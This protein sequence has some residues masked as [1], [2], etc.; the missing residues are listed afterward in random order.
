MSR[1]DGKVVLVMGG[2]TDGPPNAGEVLA[3]GNGRAI[4]IQCARE[5]ARVMVADRNGVAAQETVDVIRE[6]GHAA[7][8]TAC[9]LLD[10]GQ[11]Q[12]AVEQTVSA[13]GQLDLLANNAGITDYS[14]VTESLQDEFDRIL[15]VNLRG[16]VLAIKYALP[17]IAKVGGGAIVNISSIAA[18]RATAGS[19][20]A[21][22]SS[23]AALGG[24]M[25]NVAANA[26][27]KGVRVNNLLPGFVDSPML[28]KA[29]GGVVPDFASK[30]PLG[31]MATPWDIAKVAVFLL[32]DDAAYIS[33][34]EL[35]VDGGASIV[36]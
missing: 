12:D 19:G 16:Y 3:I 21:Y 14:D 31:R 6:E 20:I 26:G 28:R 18:L 29:A 5:G 33:G 23:K 17:E 10:A 32:S 9:D 35:L 11:C 7:E 1:L 4:A 25:R 8:A 36:V 22:D 30:V 15:A 34:V 24:M 2:G 13:F 27:A